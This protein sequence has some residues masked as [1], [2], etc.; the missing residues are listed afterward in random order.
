MLEFTDDISP[1]HVMTPCGMVTYHK[2]KSALARARLGYL[3]SIETPF[4]AVRKVKA[5]K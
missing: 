4:P 5:V 3:S 1:H 2:D